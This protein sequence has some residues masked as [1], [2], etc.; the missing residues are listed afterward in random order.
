MKGLRWVLP[1]VALLAL[2]VIVGAG[3]AQSAPPEDDAWIDSVNVAGNLPWQY[4]EVDSVSGGYT[5]RYVDIVV[6]P[7]NGTVYVSYYDATN[8]ELR[9]ARSTTPGAG[10]CGPSDSWNCSTVDTDGNVGMYS[11]IDVLWVDQSI[12]F[13]YNKIGISYYDAINK[14][15]KYA[16][17]TCAVF[18]K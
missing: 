15:L 5:G 2:A 11:S 10:N 9:M 17:Y 1:L 6:A 4:G 8:Q 3:Q 18:C 7:H 16:V 13:D 14:A 12:G